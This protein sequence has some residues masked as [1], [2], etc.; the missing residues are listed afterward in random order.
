MSQFGAEA[1]SQFAALVGDVVSSRSSPDRSRLQQ[2]LLQEIER[3]NRCFKVAFAS[4]LALTSGD[5]V[6]A[7]MAQP[8][9]AV[10][11]VVSLTEA[12]AP[13]RLIF[14]LGYGELSTDIYPN[15]TQIDGPCFHAARSALQEK[16]ADP[17]LIARG[18]GQS[19]DDVLT[20]LFTLMKAVRSRWTEKQLGYVRAV[21]QKPQKEVAAEFDVSPSTVSESLKASSFTA[22]LEG[23]KAARQLLRDFGSQ[24]ESSTNSGKRPK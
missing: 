4:P 16:D 20:S 18:F 12:I 24:T 1:E 6:Q 5:E 19:E 21:R 14:G 10:S 15:V 2:K 13:E 7:L 11:V 9:A 8:E 22:V 3:L 23:E 17:W